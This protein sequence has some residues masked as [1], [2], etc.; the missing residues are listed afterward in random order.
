LAKANG[1][2]QADKYLT[3]FCGN[4]QLAGESLM[5]D[6]PESENWKLGSSQDN[7]QMAMLELIHSDE[8]LENWTEFGCMM[9][10]KGA[11]NIPMDQAINF[12]FES[13]NDLNNSLNKNGSRLFIVKNNPTTAVSKILETNPK[14]KA[15]AF[16]R[17]FS[18]YS[19]VRDN[20]IRDLC[21]KRGV[22]I[23]TSS[24]DLVLHPYD[25]VLS[26]TGNPYTVFGSYFKKAIKLIP[27]KPNTC[28]INLSF[29]KM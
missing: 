16:N 11:K 28:K 23:I 19:R 25:A 6:W 27:P 21:K 24:E 15:V 18:P 29:D 14:I 12:M 2:K 5:L 13:L 3:Q 10:I 4:E 22:K 26:D 9:S 8:T 1:D 7:E 17:D 20:S